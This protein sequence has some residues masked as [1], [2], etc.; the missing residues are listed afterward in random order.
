M[1]EFGG[2]NVAA[3]KAFAKLI[4]G[5]GCARCHRYAEDLSP[6]QCDGRA[7]DRLAHLAA[8]HQLGDELPDH[9]VDILPWW[10]R[11]GPI[12]EGLRWSRSGTMVRFV[13]HDVRL[14]VFR[15]AGEWRAQ[16]RILG[17]RKS[18]S[19]SVQDADQLVRLVREMIP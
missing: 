4:T 18:V 12:I 1:K 11:E 15:R 8:A 19:V 17:R 2:R 3:E 7:G 6:D 10:R 13:L 9:P 14:E 5:C 16:R